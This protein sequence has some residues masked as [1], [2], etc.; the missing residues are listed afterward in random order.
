MHRQQSSQIL[1]LVIDVIMKLAVRC[2]FSIDIL[3]IDYVICMVIFI[4][5]GCVEFLLEI[6]FYF[7]YMPFSSLIA[8]KKYH[9]I[10]IDVTS[11]LTEHRINAQ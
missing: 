9:L 7:V 10:V 4:L 5:I 1:V 3:V 2:Y 8:R 11:R 6:L